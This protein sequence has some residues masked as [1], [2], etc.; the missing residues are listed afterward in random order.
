MHPVLEMFTILDVNFEGRPL[1]KIQLRVKQFTCLFLVSTSML[2]GFSFLP[3]ARA[4]MT[5][6][7]I[8]PANGNVGTQVQLT[9]N[10]TTANG[11][12][13]VTFDGVVQAVGKASGN[14]VNASF[15]VPEAVAGNY[16]VAV[17][18]VETNENVTGVFTVSTAYTLDVNVPQAPRQLQEGDSV[19]I[20]VNVTGGDSN[21]AVVANITVQTPANTTY[22][23]QLGIST[24]ALGSGNATLV[25]PGNFSGANTNYVGDYGVSLNLSVATQSFFVGL[26]NS[27]QYHRMEA[28]NIKAIYAQ[29]E[30]VTLTVS[31]KDIFGKDIQDPVNVTAD[32]AGVVD[33]SNWTV[34]VSASAG[35][36]NVSIV[37]VSGLTVKVPPDIQGFTVPGFAFNVT[38]KNLAGDQVPNVD[39]RA[40][41]NGSSIN[42]Q[43]TSSIGLAVLML[44]I[45]DYTLQG[46]YSG[47]KV[48]EGNFSVTDTEE[49]DLVLNLTNLNIRVVG[50]VN[51][52]EIG[53]P[54]VG[55]YLT[56]EGVTLTTDLTG[57]V[58]AHSLLPNAAYN[59]TASRY[60]TPFNVTTITSLLGINGS[61]V[62]VFYVNI[63]CPSF[64]LKVN[65]FKAG[66]QPF[67]NAA[68]D[69]KELVGGI[70]YNGTTDLSGT[71]TFNAIFGRYDVEIHDSAGMELN[72]T[73]VDM[74]QDQNVTL[75]CNL[76]GLNISVTVTDYF[77]Q[78]F[79][80]TKIT[81]QGNG[82]EPIS[83][84]TQANGM[85]TFDNLVGDSFSISVYLSDDGSPTAVQ[86]LL[87]QG[88]ATVLVKISKYVLLAGL[89]VETSQLAIAVIIVAS[90][91]LVLS[92][93]VYR[94][95]RNKSQKVDS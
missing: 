36:Y 80:N 61:L 30:T 38:A 87:V 72:S 31:G 89:L 60:I 15:T 13:N 22:T 18:D 40:F 2:L 9:A 47:V 77:G 73:T 62:K 12:Y 8:S 11:G 1:A 29:N 91:L 53:I 95:R 44:E 34:P 32:S 84:R 3:R 65:A 25:Y 81:L 52:V 75:Y 14:D 94:R 43:T 17:V 59:L 74:F 7:S 83:K 41:E 66:G 19:P 37:S 33:Y 21:S 16:T 24:S 63:T 20:L 57:N 46:Y 5:M 28:V 79:A 71:I 58:V 42:N 90:L 6:F 85:A 88:N 39:V 86:S 35:T 48:G 56:Q 51:G 70:H 78:P 55:I 4:G 69:V 27:T 10:L 54:E 49:V 68:V 64:T 23:E 76:F 26:T 67:D 50:V 93:E 45:G 92:L 82:S